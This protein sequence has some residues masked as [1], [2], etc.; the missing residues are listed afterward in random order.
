MA[1][2]G[3]WTGASGQDGLW[4][5]DVSGSVAYIGCDNAGGQLKV[6]KVDTSTM[7]QTGSVL[8][9]DATQIGVEHTTYY[10]GYT[11]VTA[12]SLTYPCI[13]KIDPATMAVVATFT[14]PVPYSLSGICALGAYIYV[15]DIYGAAGH[16][17]K[18]NE[19]DLTLADTWT[20]GAGQN[21]CYSIC[22]D[23]T[24]I[25]AS[26]YGLPGC[27]TQIDPATMDEVLHWHPGS[28]GRI[29]SI[30]FNS[31]Y[32]YAV[33]F[34]SNPGFAFKIDISDMTTSAFWEASAGLNNFVSTVI[35]D[36]VLYIGTQTDPAKVYKIQISDMSLLL[37]WTGG[38]NQSTALGLSADATHIYVGLSTTPAQVVRV[39]PATMLNDAPLLVSTQAATVVKTTLATGNGTVLAIGGGT[40]LDC[41]VCWATTADPVKAGNHSHASS[42]AL[43]AF[44]SAITG[45]TGATHYY[46]RAWATTTED[47]TV[48]GDNVEIITMAA[49]RYGI[50][51]AAT[52][53][54]FNSTGTWSL[55]EGGATGASVPDSGL[56]VLSGPNCVAGAGAVLDNNVNPST[57]LTA[58]WTDSTNSPEW[59]IS[60]PTTP[61]GSVTLG[62]GMSVTGASYISVQNGGTWTSNGVTVGCDWGIAIN[63]G[64]LIIA[65]PLVI[66]GTTYGLNAFIGTIDTNNQPITTTLVQATGVGIHGFT[67]GSSVINCTSLD[68]STGTVTVSAGTS[69][70]KVTGTGAVATGGKTYHNFELNGSAHALSGNPT[71]D[72][73][74]LGPATTQAITGTGTWTVGAMSRT[75]SGLISI[76]G[77]EFTKTGGGRVTLNN[78]SIANSDALPAKTFYTGAGGVDAGG[79]TGWVFAAP[80]Q[81]GGSWFLMRRRRR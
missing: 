25:Y 2:T 15:G 14:N 65:D 33:D 38:I 70:I 56:A 61:Y 19:A 42:P 28:N 21:G 53:S 18:L 79:N 23:G 5:L 22:T 6:I 7:E 52:T 72:S 51:P 31:G 3:I 59:R 76:D 73:L 50:L 30:S 9:G 68:L 32:V 13:F 64:T 27:V 26:G 58:N 1:V 41:G 60:Q 35:L 54:N 62:V 12:S 45:L 63:I 77:P 48:Y 40:A 36:G 67:F 17:Y 75:G 43:G 71:V 29:R 20:A 10:N 49:G 47:G 69:T 37:T 74:K 66:T 24:Y 4:G 11:Y 81:G 46:I 34:S 78:M 39:D 80:L 8:T 55:D 57:F 44:T 16:V